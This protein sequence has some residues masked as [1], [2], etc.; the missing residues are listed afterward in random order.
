MTKNMSA[1][2]QRRM[3]MKKQILIAA[4][5]T[6]FSLPVLA[7]EYDVDVSHSHVGFS[8]KHLVISNVK[9]QFQKLSGKITYDEAKKEIKGGSATIEASSIF[10]SD[11]KRDEHL[12]SPDFFDVEKFPE[13]KF[14][15]KN[16]K[17]QG[18]KLTVT[19]DLTIKDKTKSVTLT[20]EFLGQAKDPW[21][22]ERIGMTATGKINRKDFGLTW[23]KTTEAGGLVVG[24]EVTLTIELEAIK[25]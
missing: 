18:K 24:D 5:V 4:A 13:V 12:R 23:S 3:L 25:K 22:K 11:A 15:L 17:I 7:G 20:G 10:T 21:G 2:A 8:V 9:G 14:V 6:F 16:A 19:G 1:K